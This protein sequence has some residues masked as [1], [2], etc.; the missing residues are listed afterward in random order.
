MSTRKPSKKS[1]APNSKNAF[2]FSL[3]LPHESEK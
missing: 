3:P 1:P 2:T